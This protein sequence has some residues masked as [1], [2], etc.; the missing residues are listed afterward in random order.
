MAGLFDVIFGAIL[1][2]PPESPESDTKML[3]I[4]LKILNYKLAI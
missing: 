2:L 3:K 1:V 4:L